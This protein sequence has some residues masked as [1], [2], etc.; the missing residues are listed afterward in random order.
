MSEGIPKVR[1]WQSRSKTLKLAES[2]FDTL[3][4]LA[5]ARDPMTVS[6][7][8]KRMGHSRNSVTSAYVSNA[9]VALYKVGAIQ[10]DGKVS[11]LRISSD[12]TKVSITPAGR[13]LLKES[14][15]R[16]EF[17]RRLLERS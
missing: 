2:G 9:L 14:R 17:G 4:F 1:F 5:S 15:S 3:R 16:L 8:M 7:L 11:R 6:D 12:L 13:Q 10:G